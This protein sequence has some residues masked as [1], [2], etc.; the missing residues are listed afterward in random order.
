[1]A[2]TDTGAA[3]PPA[4]W[5]RIV[6]ISHW[7]I[8]IVILANE[9]FTR[10]GSPTHVWFGWGGL[11]LLAIRM[12]WGVIGTQEA[13]FSAFPPNALAARRHMKQLMIGKP[14]S[15]RS[16]NPAGAMMAY[17]LWACIAVMVSTGLTMSGANPFSVAQRQAIV[18]GGDW[19]QLAQTEAAGEDEGDGWVKDVHEITA[20]LIWLLVALHVGGVIVE[21]VAMRH[22]LL[23]PMLLGRRKVKAAKLGK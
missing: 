19:S 9:I 22:N 16:H 1:M 3:R 18:D 10:G 6:R 14:A 13:R 12:L 11:V 8:V 20:N 5:D 2:Q 23:A 17:A 21:S 7:G 15:Y 4:L